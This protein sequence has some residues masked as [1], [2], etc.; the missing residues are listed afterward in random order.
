MSNIPVDLNGSNAETVAATPTNSATRVAVVTGAAQGIGREIAIR[1]AVDG[2]DV[3]LND[4]PSN[5]ANLEAVREKILAT[6]PTRRCVLCTGDVS[7]EEDVIALVERTVSEL[8]SLDVVSGLC[9]ADDAVAD[10][11]SRQ[12]VANAGI[13]R[14][15]ELVESKSSSL[16]I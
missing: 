2:Y 13:V 4:I 7:E 16:R 14:I 11:T 10:M 3:A 5:S 1:L 15:S 12:M 9:N 6:G 8:G